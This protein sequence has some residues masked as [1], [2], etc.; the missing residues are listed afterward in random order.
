MVQRSC[1]FFIGVTFLFL[2][3]V[4]NN[5]GEIATSPT[6]LSQALSHQSFVLIP[7]F[8]G[9]ICNIT[10]IFCQ[11]SKI[12]KIFCPAFLSPCFTTLFYCHLIL[13]P[14][15]YHQNCSSIWTK[16]VSKRPLNQQFSAYFIKIVWTKDEPST[17]SEEKNEL[18]KTT[19]QMME[20]KHN[21]NNFLSIYWN[22]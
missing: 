7:F 2:L 21:D 3:L 5:I 20:E 9:H 4:H 10:K 6:Y 16:R 19:R 14:F 1:F 15:L 12:T 11:I 22:F 13:V 17:C 18:T 8:I